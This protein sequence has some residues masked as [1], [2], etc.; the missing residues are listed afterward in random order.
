MGDLDNFGDIPAGL[1]P[2]GISHYKHKNKM[3][4]R[5]FELNKEGIQEIA[6]VDFNPKELKK[7][8]LCI[9]DLK[10]K[11]RLDAV[12]E[13]KYFGVKKEVCE[14]ILDPESHIRFEYIDDTIYGE[15]AYFS[16][17]DRKFS[18]ASISLNT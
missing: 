18:S 12:D 7:T 15:L 11:N 14:N 9:I 13:L 4:K 8:S 16:E 10:T 6:E 5:I 1:C 3:E 17:M 2:A